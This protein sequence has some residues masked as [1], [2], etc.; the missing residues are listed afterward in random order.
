KEKKVNRLYNL[1]IAVV[2][3]LIVFV[4]GTMILGNKD[5]SDNQ[6]ETTQNN[7]QTNDQK[8]DKTAK[9]DDDSSKD[10]QAT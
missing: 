10:D 8:T 9:K 2:A 4:G 7:P 3:V 5:K 6:A 1:L